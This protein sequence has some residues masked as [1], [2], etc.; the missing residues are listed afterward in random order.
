M[1]SRWYGPGLLLVLVL[2]LA[3]PG[4]AVH[5]TP[6]P[7][8]VAEV[9]AI[10]RTLVDGV[11]EWRSRLAPHQHLVV[12]DGDQGLA[13]ITLALARY[14]PSALHLVSH[15]SPGHLALGNLDLNSESLARYRADLTRWA[16]LLPAGAD[17]LLYG[18]DVAQG[19]TGFAF[20]QALQRLTGADLAASTTPSGNPDQG[21]DWRLET[22]LGSVETSVP[23]QGAPL[24]GALKQITVTSTADSG[25]GTLREALAV[26]NQTPEDDLISLAAVSGTIALDSTLPPIRSSLVLVGDGDDRLSG[27]RAH[28]VLVVESGDVTLR[29]LTVAH[30]LAAG[31][32]GK[33][34]AGGSAGL[35]GGLLINGGQVA[36]TPMR[37]V[38]NQ[39][40]GGS[41]LP[42]QAPENTAIRLEKQRYT[43]N[44][45]AMAGINGIGGG[46]IGT[47][48]FAGGGGFGGLGNAGNGGSG[49]DGG[50]DG[51]NGG[52]GGNGGN[53]GIGIFGGSG[54]QGDLGTLGV[55]TFSGG[56]GGVGNA[57]NGG[58]GGDAQT[59]TATGGNG[60]NGGFGGG[61]GAGGWGGEGGYFGLPGSPGQ[62][63]I[64]G[65]GGGTGAMNQG[66]GG[67][68]LGGAIFLKAG[69]LILNNTVFEGNG[70]IAGEGANPVQGK[71]GAI[72]VPGTRGDRPR[73]NPQVRGLGQFPTFIDN[74]AAEATATD[75]PDWYGAIAPSKTNS[76]NF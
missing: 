39:A 58:G 59:P 61:G 17:V 16:T 27:Q 20:L 63:G 25:P 68:G 30:G 69:R 34:G 47:I 72:F 60:G 37:F 51:G 45:G 64:G 3:V 7:E 24:V 53:G 43:L 32:D 38:D 49:G 4:M 36:L 6:P 62:S 31:E 28:R 13:P 8:V 71:G 1:G 14:R 48:A 46:G 9:V 76:G 11:G 50:A 44:R 18:C 19:E 15:G 40:I 35:G 65:F 12:I 41:G 56:L 2:L 54:P 75:N 21:G 57:G 70:A 42:R 67:G 23:W 22:T 52:K 73:R 55:A 33:A 66:G 10:D 74:R 29:D 5:P 26:A